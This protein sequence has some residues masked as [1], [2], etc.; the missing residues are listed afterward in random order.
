MNGLETAIKSALA[1]SDR[2]N[3][4][5]RAR[6]YQSAR[7]A[8]ETG[9]RKQNINDPQILAEQRHRLEV[10]IHSIEQQERADLAAAAAMSSSDLSL[11]M[12]GERR[13]PAM[14]I[15]AEVAPPRRSAPTEPAAELGGLRAERGGA[16]ANASPADA[17]LGS[18]RAERDD[19]L[20][21][22]ER[23]VAQPAG[24]GKAAKETDTP[25]DIRPEKVVRQRKP[26][27]RWFSRLFI[28]LTFLAAIG[29]GAWWVY[30]TGLTMTAEERDTSVPNPPPRAEAEDF[31][32]GP[33]V[34]P[35][36]PQ[37]NF[38][39]DW[40]PVFEPAQ[41]S[42]IRAR[43]NASVETVAAS[44]GNAVRITSRSRDAGG[45]IEIAVPVSVMRE[46]AG[47]TS[48]IALTMQAAGD[49]PVQISVDCDLNLLGKCARHRFTV[50]PEKSDVLLRVGFDQAMAPANPGKL[51][52]N[53]DVAGAGHPVNLYSVRI[54][55][56]Q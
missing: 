27:R 17:G 51:I 44:D 31:S 56:G 54:L 22:N 41:A 8:L 35:L 47:K 50:N 3:A 46:M 15:P 20:T 30:S 32:E 42:E 12:R 53:G 38:S 11:D 18:M 2:T 49:K 10:L 1:R 26:R 16:P 37:Q 55:P 4:E 45:E 33:A 13:E 23:P 28:L 48:T 29:T 6:I 39:A 14:D 5:M 40:V 21:G 43:A 34:T 19:W 24:S 36:D 52:I 25:L 7:Q 9:L